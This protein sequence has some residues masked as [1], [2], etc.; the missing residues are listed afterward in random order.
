VLSVDKTFV[1]KYRKSCSWPEIYYN[2][3]SE[4]INFVDP[5]MF[6]EIGVAYGY[7][8][9]HI[10]S[11]HSRIE[12]I[13]IDPYIP[14]YDKHDPFV[15]DVA[16]LFNDNAENA[17]NRL[18]RVVT[19]NL[20]EEFQNRFRLIRESST[21]ASIQFEDHQVDFIFI[22]GNHQKNSIKADLKVWWPK[23]KVG[24]VL[25]CDDYRWPSVA[26]T[27]K[28]FKGFDGRGFLVESLAQNHTLFCI[29]K[30]ARMRS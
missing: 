3:I 27:I 19:N 26:E 20:T 12:Y 28:K 13:G 15:S 24:G 18:C 22:D 17:L 5:K 16:K 21:Q 6:I 25:V 1:R 30:T 8:A 11:T 10:L 9:K 14:D 4:L 7:H 2:L 29:R 23:I